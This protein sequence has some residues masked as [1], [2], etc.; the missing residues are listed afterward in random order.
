MS[1]TITDDA[2]ETL[3]TSMTIVVAPESQVPGM[4]L[5]SMAPSMAAMSCPLYKYSVL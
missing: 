4:L 5:Q 1:L 3:A 2:L